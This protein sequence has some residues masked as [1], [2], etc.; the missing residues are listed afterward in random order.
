MPS[1][2]YR[3]QHSPLTGYYSELRRQL[4]M[5]APAQ[6]FRENIRRVVLGPDILELKLLLLHHVPKEVAG[7]VDVLRSGV[8]FRVMTYC[9]SGLVVTENSWCICNRVAQLRK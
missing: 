9:N 4:L 5:R 2:G 1:A 3:F 8:V 6:S 7:D